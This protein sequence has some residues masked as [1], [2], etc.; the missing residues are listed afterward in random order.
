MG[1]FWGRV[2]VDIWLIPLIWYYGQLDKWFKSVDCNSIIQGFESPIDLFY[3]ICYTI[4]IDR[5]YYGRY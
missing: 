3:L 5:G 1:V 4:F 2:D